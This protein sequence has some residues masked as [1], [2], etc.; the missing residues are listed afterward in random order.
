MKIVI[1]GDHVGF[2]LSAPD[3]GTA[4]DRCSIVGS[5]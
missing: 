5:G 4:R 1:G 3:I 2:H